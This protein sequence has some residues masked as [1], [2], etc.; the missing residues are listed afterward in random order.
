MLSG[1]YSRTKKLA[2]L[3]MLSVAAGRSIFKDSR[4]SGKVIHAISRIEGRR[5]AEASIRIAGKEDEYVGMV[6][7]FL[8]TSARAG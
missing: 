6:V 3:A 2:L 8:V 4:M 5:L 1:V 7:Q